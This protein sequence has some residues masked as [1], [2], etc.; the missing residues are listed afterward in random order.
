M[1]DT[2]TV[3]G[4]R[5]LGRIGWASLP[6]IVTAAILAVLP[7]LWFGDSPYTT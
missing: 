2:E 7:P 4:S 6:I 1:S 3:G 5:R